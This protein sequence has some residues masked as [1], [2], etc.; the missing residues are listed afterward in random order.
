VAALAEID[1]SLAPLAE[2]LR[3][4]QAEL[5]DAGRELERYA[6]AIEADPARLAEL[7]E[8]VA[9]LDRLRRKYG[10]SEEEILA[11]RER[12][13]AALAETG[14]A[15]E[16]LAALDAEARAA[17]AALARDAARLSEGRRAAAG[18]LAGAV[19]EGLRELALAGAGFEVAL[20]PAP[21]PEGAPCGPGGAEAPEFLFRADAGGTPR[22]LRKVASGGEL[23]RVFLALK[24]ALRRSERG[25]VLVFDEIDA[26]TGGRSADR[27]GQAL[28]ELAPEHQVLCITHLPQVAARASTHIRVAKRSLGGRT[29][30]VL[31]A[32]EA[33]ARV[34][35]LARM[36]GGARVTDATRRH[37]RELL[38][39]GTRRRGAPAPPT[40]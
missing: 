26:G 39:A 37:A 12:A 19:E 36:A 17:T 2:R 4:A 21:A 29:V 9:R 28:A 25:M 38:E 16:R 24:G 18:R 27:V 35:E 30:A 31:E 33:E 40:R 7:D 1:A 34:D 8:R 13:A 20:P 10:A 3:G 5:A 15:D 32:L 11:F 14:A 22:P 6:E 23:S